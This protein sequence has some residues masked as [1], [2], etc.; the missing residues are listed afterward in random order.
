MY[1]G[2]V[3]GLVIVLVAVPWFA[4]ILRIPFPIIAAIILV[5][6]AIGAYTV[7][8]AAFDIVLMLI[9]GVLGYVM[10]K[11]DYPLAPLVLAL[12]LGDRTE[13]SFRQA[14]LLS[15]GSF[16]IF[17]SNALVGSIMALGVVMLF[18]PVLSKLWG[19]LRSPAP[20]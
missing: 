11:L 16:G 19:R 18:W 3:V 13:Q 14:L 1:L 10:K 7:N 15:E 6:C 5:V 9:F 12:V 4:A 17:F 8:N 20:A 2:N